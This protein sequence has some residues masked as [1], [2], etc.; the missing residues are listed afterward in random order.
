MTPSHTFF[1]NLTS[2]APVPARGI[3]SQTLSDEAGVEQIG[4]AHV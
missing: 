4:R 2:E 1:P 3:H